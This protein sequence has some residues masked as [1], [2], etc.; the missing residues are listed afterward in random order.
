MMPSQPLASARFTARGRHRTISSI[1]EY[2]GAG[3]R[4]EAFERRAPLE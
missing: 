3:A 1:L 2:R 4:E